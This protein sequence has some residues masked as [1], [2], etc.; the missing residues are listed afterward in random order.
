MREKIVIVPDDGNHW[1]HDAS[2]DRDVFLEVISSGDLSEHLTNE[3]IDSWDSVIEQSTVAR[4]CAQAGLDMNERPIQRATQFNVYNDE[5]DFNAVFQVT[6]WN[7]DESGAEWPF[8]DCIWLVAPHMGGDPRGNY[9]GLRAYFVENAAERGALDW[10]LGWDVEEFDEDLGE[11]IPEDS[12]SERAWV[13]YSSAPSSELVE[14]VGTEDGEWKGGAFHFEG[15]KYRA[16]PTCW[17]G[18]Y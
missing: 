17:A 1:L 4:L 6:V 12:M 18:S 14:M 8:A 5:N 15:G 11:W 7:V 2:I 9:G 3:E 10:V 16:F 13:G